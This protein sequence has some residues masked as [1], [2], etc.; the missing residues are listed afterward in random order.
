MRGYDSFNDWNINID[1]LLDPQP[2]PEA[3]FYNN[4]PEGQG[5]DWMNEIP[6]QNIAMYDEIMA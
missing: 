2:L 3:D 1:D 6:R 4:V 5:L